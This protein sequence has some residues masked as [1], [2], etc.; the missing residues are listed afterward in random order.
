MRGRIAKS[1]PAINLMK[2]PDDSSAMSAA[3]PNHPGAVDYLTREQETFMDRYGDW[4]WLGL[5]FGGGV[6]SAAAWTF[7]LFARRR[8]ELIDEVLDRLLSILNEARSAVDP[9]QLDELSCEIDALVI[10]AV[11]Q[12][13]LGATDTRTMSALILAIDAARAAIA[14]QR[15]RT[16]HDHDHITSHGLH[17]MNSIGDGR[18]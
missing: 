18:L 11:R 17:V 5:F 15:R 8:R 12:A 14:D 16:V 1:E 10:K 6:S 3:L 9:G 4:V 13:H 2:P 7:Q